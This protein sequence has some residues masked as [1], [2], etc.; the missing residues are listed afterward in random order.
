MKVE[1]T[2]TLVNGPWG[3]PTKLLVDVLRNG[4]YDGFAM[5]EFEL[6]D[7]AQ[8][9]RLRSFVKKNWMHGYRWQVEPH[10]EVRRYI[11]EMYMEMKVKAG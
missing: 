9:D 6:T 8:R 3:D 1:I 10:P 11:E 2:Y 4:G 7:P 5:P